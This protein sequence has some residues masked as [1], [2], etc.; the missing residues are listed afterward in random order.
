MNELYPLRFRPVYQDY[1]WGGDRLGRLFGREVPPGR[2]AESWEVADRPEGMGVV[3]NGALAG[4]T[5]H[6]LVVSLGSELMGRRVRSD[7]FPLLIKLIDAR[8]T[9]SV[10]VHPDNASAARCGGE[11]KTE[12]W[13]VLAAEPG[14]CVYCGLRPGVTR[15][16]F[17]RAVSAGTLEQLLVRVPVRPDDAV[18]VPGGRVHAIGAGCVL[19][20]CQQN[21]NTTYRLYD[22]GRVGADGR[23][24]ALHIEQALQVIRWTDH[25][26]P[27][28]KPRLVESV[29]RNERWE[30]LT[31]PYFRMERYRLHEPL[32]WRAQP[33]SFRV[34][35]VQEGTVTVSHQSFSETA[36]PGQTYL[37][38]ASCPDLVL[39]PG[40][41]PAQ[42]LVMSLP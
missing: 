35:F 23:P 28:V 25:E 9:L 6:D 12:M 22:W 29:S 8:E 27:L 32:V 33:E 24:R 7:V 17:E 42:L 36:G 1:L 19:L 21:S 16:T 11:P 26:A 34:C 14:A 38:P 13:Y 40:P 15:E 41:R 20:E 2:Q 4:R 5:L 30:V 39:Q 37:V 31:S 18:Y 3:L 10:Q